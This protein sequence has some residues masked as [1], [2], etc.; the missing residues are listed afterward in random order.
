MTRSVAGK[1]TDVQ[2]V[3]THVSPA[4]LCPSCPVWG[5]FG[6]GVVHMLPGRDLVKRQNGPSPPGSFYTETPSLLFF[7]C[8]LCP[9]SPIPTGVSHPCVFHNPR[10]FFPKEWIRNSLGAL[11]LLVHTV[12]GTQPVGHVV[13]IWAPPSVLGSTS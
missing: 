6:G 5:P 13:G 1:K 4:H 7:H 10:L 2:L 3:D 8:S 12:F 9:P 11:C